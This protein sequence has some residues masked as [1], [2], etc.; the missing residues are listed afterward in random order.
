M[1]IGKQ[2]RRKQETRH[3][4]RGSG[5]SGSGWHFW[6]RPTSYHAEPTSST[7]PVDSWRFALVWSSC[8]GVPDC[9]AQC[10]SRQQR[11]SHISPPSRSRLRPSRPCFRPRAWAV[12]L[13]S[14]RSGGCSS[15]RSTCAGRLGD[16]KC[17]LRPARRSK[18]RLQGGAGSELSEELDV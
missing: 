3:G 16:G 18:T 9:P 5:P 8:F 10:Y 2:A 1:S 6:E 7:R 15:P 4:P 14:K 11:A 17:W 12:R 13:D